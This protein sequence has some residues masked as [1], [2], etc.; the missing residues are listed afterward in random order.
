MSCPKE[1]EKEDKGTIGHHYHYSSV[2]AD[3]QKYVFIKIRTTSM[4][5]CR[6]TEKERKGHELD[7]GKNQ[8]GETWRGIG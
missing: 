2:E 7:M 6:L 4:F 1:N 8:E 5:I 3:A